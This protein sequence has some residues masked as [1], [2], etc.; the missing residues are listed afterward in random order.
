MRSGAVKANLFSSS[1]G[2]GSVIYQIMKTVQGALNAEHVAELA[3]KSRAQ[4][5]KPVIVTDATGEA[6]VSQLV[7]E[8]RQEARRQRDATGTSGDVEGEINEIRMPTLRDA[9]RRLCSSA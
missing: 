6:L 8:I 2:G 4:G 9:L 1:F 5:M 3:V 7:E